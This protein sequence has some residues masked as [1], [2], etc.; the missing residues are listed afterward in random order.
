[1]STSLRRAWPLVLAPVLA[2]LTLSAWVFASPVGAG[3]D[4]DFH[5]VSSWCAGPTAAETC[6]PGAE[7]GTAEVPVALTEVA[8]F[9]FDPDESAACQNE[10]GS[11]S[12]DA[13]TET[14]RGNF[15]GSYPPFFYAVMGTLSGDDVQTS[16]LLMRLLTV[17][18]FVGLTT[19]LFIALPAHR[20]PTLLWGWVLTTVPL[21]LFLF[22]TNN[23]SVWAWIGVGSTWIAL[24]G[25][26]EAEGRRKPALAVLFVITAFM[27]AGAR[28]DAAIFTG[29][30]IAVVMVLS[31]RRHRHFV[32]DSVLPIVV[33]LIA[34]MLFIASYF[35]RSGVSG[36][37]GESYSDP[38][39]GGAV[40][41]RTEVLEGFGL[42]A[43][44]LLNV[45]TLWTGVLGDWALGWLDTSM[46][47]LVST[48]AVAAFVAVG[49]MGLARLWPRKAIVIA[50]VI[51]VLI[52]LPLFILQRGGDVVGT[53][54]QARYLLPLIVLLAGLVMLTSRDRPI[55]LSLA[56]RVTVIIALS[57][58]HFAALHLNL[59]RYIT[60]FDASGPNLDAGIEWWWQGPVGPTAVWLLGSL[61]YTL[62]VA[63]LITAISRPQVARSRSEHDGPLATQP[64]AR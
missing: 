13:L 48:A 58:A 20:R 22:G 36:F 14:D 47:A 44:N 4:D 33:G 27:G 50:A 62:L 35:S 15:T 31:A 16:A 23:P 11:W 26:Y 60:G 56:Q 38:L 51:A 61:A 41:E 63:V 49:F 40:S 12:L 1:L 29:F 53:Q 2:V 46:P 5:L 34:L 6:V 3:P 18:L 64:L 24:L 54:V 45:T 59:R 39:R 25:Y 37:T 17:L 55:T 7:Q 32:R 9:A 57:A 43:Y 10:S 42:F 28:A 30:A 8:C 19:A 21:G 52:A